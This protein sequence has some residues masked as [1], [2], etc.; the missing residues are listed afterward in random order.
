MWTH[1]LSDILTSRHQAPRPTAPLSRQAP[2]TAPSAM[3]VPI[4]R[5]F[6]WVRMFPA[7]IGEEAP[8]LHRIK[9]GRPM[10]PISRYQG[11]PP[12]RH[13]IMVRWV[14][15]CHGSLHQVKSSWQDTIVVIVPT[16]TPIMPMAPTSNL[17]PCRAPR[18]RHLAS[19]ASLPCGYRLI[20]C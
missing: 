15:N 4:H 17:V 18:W 6:P 12:I 13:R 7:S 5:S 20:P 16:A 2:T 19:P 3:R 1:G 10:A 9:L 11:S 14:P 8:R